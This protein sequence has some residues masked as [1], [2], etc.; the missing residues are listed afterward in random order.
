MTP[1]PSP[2]KR[3]SHTSI[4]GLPNTQILLDATTKNPWASAFKKLASG[5]S[6]KRVSFSVLPLEDTQSESST[7]FK[8]VPRSPSPPATVEQLP[9]EEVSFDNDTTKLNSFGKHFVVARG[10]K[11]MLSSDD[12][13]FKSSPGIDAMAEA[14]IAADRKT[15]SEHGREIASEKPRFSPLEH[16]IKSKNKKASQG[17]TS[18]DSPFV[19]SFLISPSGKVTAVS[20]KLSDYNV[21][22]NIDAIIDDMGSFL[23]GW[24]I[25]TELQRA[26]G[27][28]SGRDSGSKAHIS[29]EM[30]AGIVNR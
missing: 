6:A 16:K 5:K 22:E 26:N 27:A 8:Q 30:L 4:D 11:H 29:R 21:E 1:T 23:E 28:S 12:S 15:S 10:F 3:K 17:S 9:G 2:E 19:D 7:P 24:D 13:L 14:F 20:M 25:E 18:G